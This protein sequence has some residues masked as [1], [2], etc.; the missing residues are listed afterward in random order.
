MELISSYLVPT[1]ILFATPLNI[2]AW[3]VNDRSNLDVFFIT[4]QNVIDAANNDISNS[5][6]RACRPNHGLFYAIFEANAYA[7]VDTPD[8]PSTL[9][10]AAT[11]TI[12]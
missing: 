8:C 4:L 2:T 10:P 9:R 5:F 11:M 3:R 6:I 12:I 7:T 1:I